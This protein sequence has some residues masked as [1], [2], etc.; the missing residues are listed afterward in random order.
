MSR[1]TGDCT[2]VSELIGQWV[3]DDLAAE[4][5]RRIES[6]LLTCASCAWEA[7][8]Q[9]IARERLREHAGGEVF[10]S[11]AFRAR[12]LARLRADNPHIVT[13]AEESVNDPTQ[14]R[15]PIGL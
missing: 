13:P 3:D 6:H 15:L 1:Q 10:A 11:D 9:R 2:F 4:A 8:T 7:Q 12:T 14:Y 5:R